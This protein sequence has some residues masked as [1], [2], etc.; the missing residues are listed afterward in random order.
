MGTRGMGTVI[1]GANRTMQEQARTVARVL[2]LLV[3][4][5]VA[6]ESLT[7]GQLA[8]SLG[9]PASSMHRLLQKLLA[10]GYLDF[11]DGGPSYAVSPKLAELCERLADAGC[12]SL[13]MR[14]LLTELRELTGHNVMIWVPSGMHVRIAAL[15]VGKARQKTNSRAGEQSGPFSTPGLAIAMSYTE[16]QVRELARHCRRRSESLGRN[17]HTVSDVLQ[18]LRAYKLKGH[19]SGYNMV[20][21]G[22]AMLAWPLPI[23]LEPLRIGALAVGAPAAVLRRQEGRLIELTAPRIATYTQQRAQADQIGV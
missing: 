6:P 10:L 4:L 12:R 7:N 19:V 17:F 13:P 16:R 23:T 15:L 21:D 1:E 20:A 9:V 14:Q 2:A 8:Q 18:S 22:W 5:S 3:E 11:D